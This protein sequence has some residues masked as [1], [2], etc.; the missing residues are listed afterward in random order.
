MTP[1][2]TSSSIRRKKDSVIGSESDA[3]PDGA[4]GKI[5]QKISLP[6]KL[7]GLDKYSRIDSRYII[8]YVKYKNTSQ[9]MV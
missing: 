8:D 4:S 5:S 6:S 3:E 1:T 7:A 2:E 9:F